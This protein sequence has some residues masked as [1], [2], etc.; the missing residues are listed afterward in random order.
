M[1]L[2]VGNTLHPNELFLPESDTHQIDALCGSKARDLS[3]SRE[4]KAVM[5]D[6]LQVASEK[7]M[8]SN[9]ISALGIIEGKRNE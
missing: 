6:E 1:S 5:R 9:G 4:Q 2:I 8:T 3:E 7:D